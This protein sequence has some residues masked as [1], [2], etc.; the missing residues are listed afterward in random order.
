MEQVLI[1]GH[2]YAGRRFRAALCHLR[3]EGLPVEVV[4][5]VDPRP[6]QLPDDLPGYPD[7]ATALRELRPTV[8]CVTVNEA[9]HATVFRALGHLDRVLVLAEKPL[10]AD[11]RDEQSV[12]A[13]LGH[14]Q[15]SMN[16]VE[17]FSPMVTR[18]R[19]WMRAEG[20][21]TVTRT[22]AFWGKHR[23]G[24]S[25]PT[26]G[27][28]SELIH[29]LDLLG[30]LFGAD[31]PEIIR[32]NGV[33]SDVSPHAT[34]VLD[35]LDVIARH[36]DAP[37]LLH[38]SYA[39]PTRMRLVTALLWSEHR[40]T[41]RIELEFDNPHWDCDRLEIKSITPD[42]RWTTV[43]RDSTDVSSL[44]AEIRGVGKV[45]EFVRASLDGWWHGTGSDALVDLA[46]AERL[47][48]ILTRIG[49]SAEDGLLEARYGRV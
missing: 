35:S 39:W 19:E 41:H 28:L 15:F 46:A 29:A 13:A 18:C 31:N 42:G 22:E 1:V 24:D 17:R 40:G 10:V 30:H 49:D 4:G 3:R 21:W 12:V 20:P 34:D 37:M 25:R 33:L 48:G 45:I 27:V 5:V 6:D 14:H 7:L 26:M 38:T 23:I 9:D 36:G 47:Q 16:L 32:S 44:P 43:L 11:P 2:G 8:V